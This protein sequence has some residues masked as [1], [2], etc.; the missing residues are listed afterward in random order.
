[1]AECEGT[2]Y[3]NIQLDDLFDLRDSKLVR[4]QINSISGGTNSA[5]ITLLDPCPELDLVDLTAVPFFYHCEWSSGTA[6]DL[7][8][9]FKAF[10]ELEFVY[11]L[12]TPA[13]GDDDIAT[14]YIVGHIDIHST[15]FCSKELRA[16]GSQAPEQVNIWHEDGSFAYNPVLG[17]EWA[18]DFNIWE[19]KVAAA[20][21]PTTPFIDCFPNTVLN[22][23]Y[24]NR[25]FVDGTVAVIGYT[26]L[27]VVDGV[28]E[29]A[30]GNYSNTWDVIVE[31]VGGDYPVNEVLRIR[32]FYTGSDKLRV[33]AAMSR[34]LQSVYVVRT[35]HDTNHPVGEEDWKTTY[36][37]YAFDQE[38]GL[39]PLVDT[40]LVPL[41]VNPY[42]N[43]G[44]M[45]Y[46]FVDRDGNVG[47]AWQPSLVDLDDNIP[48]SETTYGMMVT[49]ADGAAGGTWNMLTKIWD[50]TDSDTC[51]LGIASSVSFDDLAIVKAE[52]TSSH[53]RT[54]IYEALAEGDSP[55]HTFGDAGAGSNV[56]GVWGFAS[57]YDIP[58]EY[59]V[60]VGGVNLTT[61]RFKDEYFEGVDTID[62]RAVHVTRGGLVLVRD[63]YN[64]PPLP[65]MDDTF[66]FYPGHLDYLYVDWP[67]VPLECDPAT[68]SRSFTAIDEES[69]QAITGFL[70][71]A[72]TL[73]TKRWRIYR[74]GSS[75]TNWIEQCL[76][77]EPDGKPLSELMAM[78]WRA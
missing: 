16:V 52:A 19:R 3:E 22:V 31:R 59:R 76:L 42:P 60:T 37:N 57:Y 67:R 9:G 74:N 68:F 61:A 7:Q 66:L 15:R 56:F 20:C 21:E 29:N 41:P 39:W 27:T 46:W 1:M 55:L 75:I 71:T 35:R 10:E 40:G 51:W 28:H 58:Y 53:T 2:D 24:Q 38:T 17:L 36:F 50:D 23:R 65:S 77:K 69:R 6:R 43:W 64:S 12:Y 48:I 32:F 73:Q 13:I 33:S 63:L 47:G 11:V 4:A 44:A 62:V 25:A 14:I 5:D 78:Y 26:A 54:N 18:E 30:P 49:V 34:D 45:P 70:V 72:G 8:Y